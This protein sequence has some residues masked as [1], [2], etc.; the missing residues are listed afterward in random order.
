[1]D[2]FF[3]PLLIYENYI[4]ILFSKK[5]TNSEKITMLKKISDFN[6]KHDIIHDIIFKNNKWDIFAY[7]P[8]MTTVLINT[9]FKKYELLD[10]DININYRT[11]FTNISQYNIKYRKYVNII[12]NKNN[13]KIRIKDIDYILKLI[14]YY[15]K[16]KKINNG[17]I[18]NLL[19]YYNINYETFIDLIRLN[20]NVVSVIKKNEKEYFIKELD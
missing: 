11:I 15:A 9:E 14:L 16:N 20:K 2:T 7:M 1:M 10:K 12:L 5:C 17:T 8:Y 4:K 13:N 6:S 3:I 18:L 19:K